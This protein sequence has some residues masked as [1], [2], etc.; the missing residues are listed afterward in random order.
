MKYAGND[1]I[2]DV[3]LSLPFDLSDNFIKDLKIIDKE[4]KKFLNRY[5]EY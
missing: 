5:S 2:L 4:V 3:A 1:G